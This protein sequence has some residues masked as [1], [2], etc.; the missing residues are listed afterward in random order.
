M[1]PIIQMSGIERVYGHGNTEVRALD[2]VDLE[3][4]A[5]EFVA[6]IW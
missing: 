6:V 4:N 1:N 3:L 2:G 5:G